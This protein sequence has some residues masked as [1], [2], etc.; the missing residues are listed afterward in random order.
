AL[1]FARA[2]KGV[3]LG[4]GSDLGRIERQ[5]YLLT[6]V[7][8]DL[9]SRNLLTDSRQLYQVAAETLEALT[10]SPELGSVPSLVGL[11][12]SLQH[13]S[14]GDITAITAPVADYAPDPNRVQLTA[15]AEEV[16]AAIAA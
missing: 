3:G 11:A 6:T 1:A 4:D 13:V 9:R 14:S 5:Q 15:Q 2:R 8:E 16:W 7:F 12:R 10:M